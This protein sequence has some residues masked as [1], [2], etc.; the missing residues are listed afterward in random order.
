MNTTLAIFGAILDPRLM[1]IEASPVCLWL[2]L[3]TLA[4]ERRELAA[5]AA[6]Q[7]RR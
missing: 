2:C 4:A 3:R 6:E 1:L 7:V 5:L